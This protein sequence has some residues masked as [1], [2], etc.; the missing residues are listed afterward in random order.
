MDTEPL[1][2]Y[3]TDVWNDSSDDVPVLGRE[4]SASQKKEKERLCS[5]YQACFEKY[6]HTFANGAEPR[7]SDIFFQDLRR[8]MKEVY[9][10]SDDTLAVLLSPELVDASRTFYTRSRWFDAQLKPEEI[11]QAMRN[12]WITNGLQLLT[13]LPVELTPSLLAYSLLYPYSD[14]LLDDPEITPADKA[15]FSSRFEQ[16]LQAVGEMAENHRETKISELVGIIEKQY[17]R[18]HFPEVYAGLLAI[19]QAQ[20][21]SL[22]LNDKKQQLSDNDVLSI[23]FDK[24]GASVLADGLL[25]SG[26]LSSEVQRF[27]FGFGIWLQLVDDIQDLAEDIGTGTQTLFTVENRRHARANLAHRT[28]HFGR[29]IMELA[30]CFQSAAADSF[31]QSIVQNTEMMLIQAIGMNASYYAPEFV[32]RME[33]YSPVSFKYLQQMKTK[34]MP[35]RRHMLATWLKNTAHDKSNLNSMYRPAAASPCSHVRPHLA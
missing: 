12:L 25:L 29:N 23:C 24:G 9:E 34:G 8:F 5:E 2:A 33:R 10:Y 28:F 1:I 31:R 17:P 18:T 19:H 13:G 30:R 7:N 32:A 15:A 26:T 27:C 3:F 21:R 22:A 20:T 16:R 6:Q 35:G 14:N 11:F 4:S